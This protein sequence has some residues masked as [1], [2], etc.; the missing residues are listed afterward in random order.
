MQDAEQVGFAREDL[1]H[2]SQTFARSGNFEEHLSLRNEPGDGARESK[3]RRHRLVSDRDAALFARGREEPLQRANAGG[4]VVGTGAPFVREIRNVP[5][6]VRLIAAV[7]DQPNARLGF[8]LE[9]E[10]AVV[11]LL[12]VSDGA[13]HPYAVGLR[14]TTYFLTLADG[15]HHDRTVGERV[16][17]HPQVSLFEHVE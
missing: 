8:Q 2:K 7:G 4:K 9:G 12:V 13:A 11:S 10:R 15:D 6:G 17:E 3:A 5:Q 16:L 1:S 14:G